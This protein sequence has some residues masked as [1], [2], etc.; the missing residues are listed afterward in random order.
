MI[1]NV[2]DNGSVTS[3]RGQNTTEL[4]GYQSVIDMRYP[5]VTIAKRADMKFFAF[6][7][8]EAL[9]ILNGDNRVSTIT[10][11]SKMI[12][13]FSDDG[14]YFK[15]AY[16]VKIV[17]QL[18]YVVDCLVN[19]PDT[20]QAYINIWRENPR[21]TKDVPCTLGTQFVI[22]K[23]ELHCFDNMRSSDAWLGWPFDVFNFSMLSA[24]VILLIKERVA[25]TDTATLSHVQ[26]QKNEMLR[27]LRLGDLRL[28]AG[29]QHIYERNFGPIK[30]AYDDQTPAFN[31]DP[32][33]PHDFHT[34]DAFLSYLTELRDVAA[35][36]LVT[37]LMP[38]T[39]PF[40]KEFFT[41]AQNP[42]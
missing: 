21:D 37:N 33:N 18:T 16:G 35:G 3:P 26:H 32:L 15:G 7:F 41:W 11:Y 39:K 8:A 29:S 13:R 30:E 10:P 20:R 19:D 34:P 12:S 5:V 22:R 28:T 36:D 17:D 42:S 31:Y 38:R 27:D 1:N 25:R 4:L 6:M 14:R 23:G 9:W 2:G 24:L 40:L